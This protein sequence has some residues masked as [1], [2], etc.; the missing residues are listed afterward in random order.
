MI[1]YHYTCGHAAPKIQREGWLRGHAHPSLPQVAPIVWLC[2]MPIVGQAAPVE[3]VA[4]G[5]PP[6]P[7]A[8]AQ[9]CDR[10]SHRVTV[11][12]RT[13]VFR[14]AKWARRNLHSAQ[15][16]AVELNG[17]GFLPAHWWVAFHGV[18]VLAVQETAEPLVWDPADDTLDLSVLLGNTPQ[19]FERSHSRGRKTKPVR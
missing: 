18:P 6:N 13:G 17:Q 7:E 12:V 9:G 11:A 14:W 1:L 8:L 4:L 19:R 15:Y 3:Q 5:M 10:F 16:Q 2:D